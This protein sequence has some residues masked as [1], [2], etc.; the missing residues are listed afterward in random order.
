MADMLSKEATE[1]I[2]SLIQT[3]GFP[4]VVAGFLLWRYDKKLAELIAIATK[5]LDLQTQNTNNNTEIVK[6]ISAVQKS[7]D[8]MKLIVAIKRGGT[9]G[10]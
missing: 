6:M 9:N 4:V 1:A 2:I 10:G 8:E 3:V 5:A 7:T